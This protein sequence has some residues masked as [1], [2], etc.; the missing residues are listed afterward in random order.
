PATFDLVGIGRLRRDVSAESARSD[1][2][3]V[4]PGITDYFN[5]EVSA[6]AWQQ[7]HVTPHVQP[8]RDSIVGPVSRLL[9]LLFGSVLLVLLVACTNVAGLF[10]V[11]A[12]SMRLELAVRSALGSGRWGMIVLSLS[13]SVL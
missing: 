10:L 7:A 13:E 2:A 8:L 3:R 11:R 1:L 9:W 6:A 12:E 4:L 5:G